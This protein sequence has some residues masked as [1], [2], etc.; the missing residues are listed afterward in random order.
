MPH[1]VWLR[2]YI[3]QNS[4]GSRELP[5]S[6][7]STLCHTTTDLGTWKGCSII[8]PP[9][10]ASILCPPNMCGDWRLAEMPYF[11]IC[12][13][14]KATSTSSIIGGKHQCA[15]LT[16]ERLECTEQT[17]RYVSWQHL[18]PPH[19]ALRSASISPHW[20]PPSYRHPDD[21]RSP[22]G[23]SKGTVPKP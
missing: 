21:L 7:G 16:W 9:N 1:G 2:P 22:K 5:L 10:M 6:T 15:V 23:S 4:L 17:G 18:P 13:G 8:C 12:L 3:A 19:P 11:L 14:A 20:M